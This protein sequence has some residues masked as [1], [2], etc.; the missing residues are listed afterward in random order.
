MSKQ[1][2]KHIT[3]ELDG[4]VAM[5]GLSRADKRNAVNDEM[6]ENIL[7]AADRAQREAR[8]GLLFGH[9]A[10]FCAGLDLGEHIHKT[11]SEVV[12]GSR[13]WHVAFD[14]I[15]K[16]SIPF[17][18]ALHGAVIGGGLEL[19]ASAHIRV[20]DQN[21]FFALP[22]GQRGIFLGGG[23]SVRIARL[24]SSARIMDLMLTGR[25]L[26]AT[27]AERLNL[28]QYVEP[29]GSA[30]DKA[31]ALAAAIASNAELSNFAIINAIPRIQD[32]SQ[33]DGLFVESLVASFTQTDAQSTERLRAFLDKKAPRIARPS[34]ATDRIEASAI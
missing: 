17:V 34:E 20:A 3:Y 28:V 16:S 13:R 25:S 22:E 4:N 26:S 2:M 8:V 14:R 12:R 33:D 30:L 19:A 18:A 29:H 6:I 7:E 11:P 10:H 1:H 27:D 32:M 15:Q 5:I 23:G 21:A 31:K 9:G 24:I